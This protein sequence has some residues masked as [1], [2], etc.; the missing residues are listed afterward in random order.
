MNQYNSP[1]IKSV[2]IKKIQELGP[3]SVWI[4][5]GAKVRAIDNEFT[6][7]GE[8]YGFEI[9]PEFE[10]WL[11]QE[12]DENEREFFIDL[13]LVEWKLCR[14]G[15][16]FDY[17]LG[18]GDSKEKSERKKCGDLS[19]VFDKKGSPHYELI[20]KKLL[21]V[22]EEGLH[23][24]R[25][26]GRLVRSAFFIDFTEGGH[27]Y[28]YDFVPHNEVW[29]DDDLVIA[30]LPFVAIH[31]IHERNLMKRGWKYD[32]AHGSASALEWTLRHH[33]EKIKES[34]G[35]LGIKDAALLQEL[36]LAQEP[37]YI[38]LFHKLWSH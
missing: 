10:F 15:K 34:L 18:K 25:V 13:L 33:P 5:D 36:G 16:T 2:Y 38:E 19:K 11:D 27:D 4:V 21:G 20:H 12:A 28:V 9:I 7:F 22:T 32:D 30:E 37:L 23:V 17:A 29:L 6:N 26:D 8:H 14:H 35:E 3:I 31:E 24:W 1:D